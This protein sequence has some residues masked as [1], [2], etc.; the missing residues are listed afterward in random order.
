MD[1]IERNLMSEPLVSILI[2]NYNY[3]RFLGAAIDSALSQ[4]YS[5]IEV[6]IVDD[7]ST[8]N[9]RGV[10]T[11]YAERVIPVFKENG[12]QASA[13]NAGVAASRGE[14][15]CFLDADDFLHREKVGRVVR[16]FQEHG[17][18]SNPIM[19]HHLLATADEKGYPLNEPPLGKVHPSPRNLYAF[20]RR[21]RFVLHDAGPTTTISINR[22]LADRLFPIPERDIRVS[23][24]DF[25]VLGA[26]LLG[27]VYS[28]PEILGRYRVHDHNQW[29]HGNRRKSP[30]FDRALEA[31]LNAKLSENGRSPVICFADSARAWWDLIEDRDWGNLVRLMAKLCI[32]DHDR[33]TFALTYRAAAKIGKMLAN[34]AREK[35]G[36]LLS[37]IRA[38]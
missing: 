8:D 24:D 7:G 34:D 23:A 5:S 14:I 13:F 10:I 4:D 19:I 28:L 1:Y 37:S 27:D 16:V 35:C 3:G 33:Y 6:V 12:G 25:I 30:E 38:R 32:K 22:A 17:L 20:A 21:H 9:S 31:Y 18:I 2:N 26:L 29:F 36:A 11:G 15:L